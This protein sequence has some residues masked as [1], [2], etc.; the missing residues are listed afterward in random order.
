[1]R[2]L[3]VVDDWEA[4]EV[5]ETRLGVMFEVH[6]AAFGSEGVRMAKELRP[7]RVLID[8][9][10]EDMTPSEACQQLRSSP[11]TRSVPLT[12]VLN[13][14]EPTPE[15]EGLFPRSGDRVVQR[16]YELQKLLNSLK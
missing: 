16:P 11:E 2:L 9:T 15:L 6:C 4:L 7:D 10:L 12:L 5:Y 8:L 14:D 13:V 3:L 1:M